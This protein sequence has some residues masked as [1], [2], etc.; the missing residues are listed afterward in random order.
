MKSLEGQKAPSSVFI[1]YNDHAYAKVALDSVSADYFK[2]N[3]EKFDDNLFRQLIWSA[4][5]N[6]LRDAQ[7]PSQEVLQLVQE[8]VFFLFFSSF[9]F[10]DC[11]VD[12]HYRKARFETDPKLVQFIVRTAEGALQTFLPEEF[13]ETYFNTFFEFCLSRLP[14]VQNSDDK[15]IWARYIF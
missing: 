13:H 3:V 4:F 1:N 5:A 8:Y 10:E 15:I 6:M 11:F 12:C 2:K 9:Y 14:E 7:Y